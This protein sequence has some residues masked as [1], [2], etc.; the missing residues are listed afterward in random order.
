[1]GQPPDAGGHVLDA[2]TRTGTFVTHLLQSGFI[3][4]DG[5]ERKFTDELHANEM[6]LVALHRSGQHRVDLLAGASARFGS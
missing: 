6:L 5:L 2:F 1:M 4:P 3:R